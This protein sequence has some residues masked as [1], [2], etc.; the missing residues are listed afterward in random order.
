VRILVCMLSAGSGDD[1]RGDCQ[2]GAKKRN[3]TTPGR[4]GVVG[5]SRA[6]VGGSLS[7]LLATVALVAYPAVAG[8]SVTLGSEQIV[9]EGPGASAVITRAPF[10]VAFRD[11]A[12]HTVLSE[13]ASNAGPL[14]VSPALP[15]SPAEPTGPTLYAPM[16]FLVGTTQL[17]TFTVGQDE[18]NLKAAE[19]S[20]T[21]YSAREVLAASPEGAGVKLT[22]S[23]D[24]PSGR[25]LIVTIAPDGAGA[26]RVSGVPS[27]PSGVAAMADS[28]SSPTGEA[29]HGF[30]GRHNS[31]NEAGQHFYNWVDQENFAGGSPETL[32][33][34][35]PQAAYY[36]Q[37]SFVSS[38]GYGLLLDRNELSAWRLDSDR[39]DAWQTQ[40][41]SPAI[42]YV[43]APGTMTQAIS[44]LTAITGRQRTPPPWAL[45]PMFD[46]EVE[47][48]EGG[49]SRYE[50][51]LAGDIKR[52]ASK[53]L[54]LTAYR[55]EGWQMLSK[56]VLES[57]IA[58]LR[59]LGVHP[60]VYFRAFVGEDSGT[61]DPNEFK[62]AVQ[63][64]YVAKTAGGEP[65]I[66]T[67]NFNKPAGV[68][69]FTNPAAVT[70]W[71]GR[72]D[73]ALELGADGF[74]LD[75]GEQVLPDMHFS[76]GSTGTQMHNRYPVL[77]Q[78]VTR[79]AVEE[80]EAAHPGRS[81]FFFTRSG[82]TGTPGT[83]AYENANFP[84]DETTDWGA[85]SGLASQTPDMLNRAIGG[86]YG[87]ST[88]IGGY[89]DVF[90]PPTTK[91]L[92]VRWAEWAALSPLFRLH[93]A[94]I[95][96]HTPWSKAIRSGP[97]YKQYSK[98]HIS[99]EP[100]IAA[101]WKQADETGLPVTR[102][103]YL[104]YPN[105]SQAALQNQEWLLGP[106]VLVA[107]V[108]ERAVSTRTVY[109]PTGCWRN[110]ETGQEVLGPQYASVGAEASQLPF[111]F[112]CGT[113]P[114]T[115]PG[116]F[117]KHLHR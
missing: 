15:G 79:A 117:G 20:G 34:N 74:M 56:P 101:L 49:A 19:E 99:A 62:T 59:A 42:S 2:V 14:E 82:Y 91:E 81:V 53:Q 1:E 97:L 54:L 35:G 87:Y 103:L 25:Q 104:A 28:F 6:L 105:D 5:A 61:D 17:S 60:L 57:V 10:G 26:I 88:D 52:I 66:F 37:S 73:A 36:V 89:Y 98:L 7:L 64:G 43:V 70:W 39:P 100:L 45:G 51:Q 18:G 68:I 78:Q 75:F 8:A 107:P 108:I 23:T 115:P 90:S 96:E 46:R 3:S 24:D 27:D 16:S 29:F 67:D 13:L 9:V 95:T 94:L 76:D 21:E 41:F 77:Y 63:Q 72:I 109:F 12:G 113:E 85:A 112:H 80:Y 106:D 69:D 22:L 111:F 4:P 38:H 33:P 71:K 92:F 84:G 32:L 48:Y 47:L 114:F 93:G 55:I 86:A 11:A 50:R 116:R 102:P 110:P 40:S 44:T 65:Y 83:A 30:G 58:Q 31:L